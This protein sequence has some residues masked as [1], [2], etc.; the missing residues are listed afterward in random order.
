MSKTVLFAV[1][2]FLS[3]TAYAEFRIW[4]NARGEIMEGEFITLN[5]GYVIIRNQGGQKFRYKP[6]EL[7][8][9]D[10]QYLEQVVPPILT[11]DVAKNSTNK[12]S[13]N[14]ES[15]KCRALIKQTDRKAY[16]GDL[17]AVFVVMGED[18]RTGRVSVSSRVEKTFTLPEER[19]EPVE[20][21][22]QTGRFH[23][24][25]SKSGRKY[26]GYLLVVWDRFG[27]MVSVRGSRDKYEEKASALGCPK[28]SLA[29]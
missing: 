8:D 6:E 12:G 2:S 21:F 3:V 4:E 15:V 17:T 22:S 13:S 9:A 24:S 23:K 26:A 7:C 27:G 18:I 5:G 29:R 19:G 16:G 25:A 10:R 28:Q 14:M 20:F 11:L 1:L